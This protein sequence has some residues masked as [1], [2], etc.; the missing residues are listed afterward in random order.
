MCQPRQTAEVVQE[1]IEEIRHKLQ[2][3]GCRCV[4]L[5]TDNGANMIAAG[6]GMANIIT[7]NCAAHTGQLL[8]KDLCNV[9]GEALARGETLYNFFHKVHYAAVIYR[10]EMLKLNNMQPGSA[11][12]LIQPGNT[13]WGSLSGPQ[14]VVCE[15][16]WAC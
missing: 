1:Y 3:V 8:I 13:R 6:R 7:L 2:G 11:T 15:M 5:V 12:L 10:E 16:G 14:Q 9:W 4:A